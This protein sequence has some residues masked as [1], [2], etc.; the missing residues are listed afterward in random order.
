MKKLIII[1]AI[2][3]IVLNTVAY[4]I[5]SIYDLF[6]NTLVNFSIL[7]TFSILYILSNTK[8]ADAYRIALSLIYSCLGLVKIVFSYYSK[9]TF[10]DNLIILSI[11]GLIFIEIILL[12]L[13][14]YM[15][16]QVMS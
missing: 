7:S 9:P 6:N 2:F 13:I 4:L 5:F 10:S 11:L 16:K 8:H 3:F 14:K 12:F 1:T 15:N